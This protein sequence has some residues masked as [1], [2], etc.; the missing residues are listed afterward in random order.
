MSYFFC[1]WT[2]SRVASLPTKYKL[3]LFDKYELNYH[4]E[5]PKHT[6]IN[7]WKWKNMKGKLKFKEIVEV[8]IN[9]QK[10]EKKKKQRK[11]LIQKKK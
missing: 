8:I 9:L 2:M 11:S 10:T 4:S 6:L 5:Y 3:I 1:I 7:G